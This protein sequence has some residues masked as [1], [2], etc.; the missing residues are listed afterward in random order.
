MWKEITLDDKPLIDRFFR[1]YPI[2][3]SDYTFTNLWIWNEERHYRYQVIE[4][5]LCIRFDFQGSPTYLMPIGTSYSQKLFDQLLSD[6][7]QFRMRA[8]S[9]EKIVA[10]QSFLPSLHAMEEADHFDFLYR[11]DDL[12]HLKGNAL[13]PKRNLVHQF[14]DHYDFLYQAI[15]STLLPK[16]IQMHKRLTETHSTKAE[17]RAL[18]DFE[19]LHI[20]GGAL[21]VDNE[22]IAYTLGEKLN[23]DTWVIHEEKALTEFKGA[24]QAIN[25]M[26]LQH[27][28]EAT[29][30]NREE[31]L[32]IPGLE[33]AKHSYHPVQM[34]KKYILF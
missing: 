11:F 33:Q 34:I 12:K 31:D 3:L 18:Q 8:I 14:E 25:Q 21:L 13:Q 29:Y 30:V 7:P 6:M 2:T 9:E 10:V 22:V 28:P 23:P 4:G 16:V 24:Y 32:G 20:Q 1:S 19:R 5:C 15:D 17:L 27:L 26:F